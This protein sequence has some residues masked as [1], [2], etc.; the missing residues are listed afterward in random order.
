V[1][2]ASAADLRARFD[3]RQLAALTD[4]A[5]K[6]A[7]DTRLAQACADASAEIDGYLQGRYVVPAT[8]V[9]VVLVDRCCDL[10]VY[11]LARLRPAA[12]VASLKERHD[13]AI[14][15]LRDVSR[16]VVTL[17]LSAAGQPPAAATTGP[18]LTAQP[19]R[20]F[21]TDGLGAF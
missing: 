10:A 18:I 15:W 7:D 5:G 8:P 20:L 9:P 13:E 6:L 17:A 16:G 21:G 3:E 2:Y 19:D 12:M 11:K 1:A 4:P 14:A